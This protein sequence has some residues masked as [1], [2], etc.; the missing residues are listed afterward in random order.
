[1]AT[2]TIVPAYRRKPQCLSSSKKSNSPHIFLEILLRYCKLVIL[3][4]LC[5]PGHAQKTIVSISRKLCC[6]SASKKSA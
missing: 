3:G 5:T 4:A 2:K 6:L 1:M